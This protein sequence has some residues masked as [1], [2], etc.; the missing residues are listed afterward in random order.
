V[1]LSVYAV[2]VANSAGADIAPALAA[3]VWRTKSRRWIRCFFI[4]ILRLMT[5]GLGLRLKAWTL[6]P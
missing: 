2:N 1:A 5:Q 3:A 4:T 6:E